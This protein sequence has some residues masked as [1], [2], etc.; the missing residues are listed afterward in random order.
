MLMRKVLHFLQQIPRWYYQM[1]FR[2][3]KVI[4]TILQLKINVSKIE[5][6]SIPNGFTVKNDLL[7]LKAFII[8]SGTLTVTLTDTTTAPATL[9][10]N[11]RITQLQVIILN[12]VTPAFTR[13]FHVKST[14]VVRPK[15]YQL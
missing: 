3:K 9:S 1:L 5:I 14:D 11:M 7:V 15:T 2:D 6:T 4:Q 8:A 12:Y 10:G 13:I